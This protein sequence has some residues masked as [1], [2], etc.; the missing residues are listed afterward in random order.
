MTALRLGTRASRLAT[1]QS[2]WVA[3]R[4]RALGH[5]VDLVPVVTAGDL[6]TASLR[7]IGGTGVFASALRGALRED[8][9]D[10]AVHSL[11]DLPSAGEPDLVLAAIPVREDPRDAVFTTSGRP[12][13]E[14]P[15]GAVIGT[16]SPR[17]AAQLLRH[18]PQLRIQDLR[19][20]VDTRLSRVAAGEL[21]GVVL[22]AAGVSRLGRLDEAAELLAPELMLPAPGQGALAVECRADR[23]ELRTTLSALE[24]PATRACV[25]AEREVLATLEAGCSAPVAAWCRTDGTRAP[26]VLTLTALLADGTD[27]HVVTLTGVD[28]VALGRRAGSDLLARRSRQRALHHD[29]RARPVATG[30]PRTAAS[31]STRTTLTITEPDQ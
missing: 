16:G 8:R 1:T 14:L 21:D 15:S 25:T 24:D 12:L 17:R 10:L 19:G 28:P 29:R 13:S 11:K 9:I 7:E 31:P 6:S 30:P 3:E 26:D 20:N 22:A 5:D 2:T 18:W 27:H 23:T 4:L